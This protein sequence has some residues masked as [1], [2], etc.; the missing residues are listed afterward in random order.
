MHRSAK[1][2]ES[3]CTYVKYIEFPKRKLQKHF[4]GECEE[5]GMITNLF[6]SKFSNCF[7]SFDVPVKTITYKCTKTN[8]ATDLEDEAFQSL[9][10]LVKMTNTRFSMRVHFSTDSSFRRG[11]LPVVPS[12]AL[13]PNKNGLE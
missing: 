12:H 10:L 8:F 13:Y 7:Q 3:K 4:G 9:R 2:V 6:L 11:L 1:A 5:K